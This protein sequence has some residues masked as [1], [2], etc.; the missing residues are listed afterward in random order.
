M[1]S[2]LGGGIML[3]PY[4]EHGLFGNILGII[5]MYLIALAVYFFIKPMMAGFVEKRSDPI[6]PG[7]D[8]PFEEYW[9]E[10]SQD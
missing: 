6:E 2:L 1:C 3:F 4:P 10:E 7:T 9:Q 5:L 8:T